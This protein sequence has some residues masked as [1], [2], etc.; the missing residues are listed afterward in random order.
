M[1]EERIIKEGM[2]T[3]MKKARVLL[4]NPPTA[5]Q[6]SEIILSLAYLASSLRKHGHEVKILDATAPYKS[7][8]AE[9]VK[10]DILDFSPH[11]IGVTLTITYIPQTYEY[12]MELRK[13]GIPIVAGGPHVNPLPGEAL[14]HGA[15]IVV[16]GEGENTIVE[17]ADHFAGNGQDL[18]SIAGLCMKDESGGIYKTP[19]RELIKNLDDIP[20]PSFEDFPI[21]NYTGSDDPESNPIFWAVFSSRGCP[22]NCTFCCGHNVFGRSYR[23]R[24]AQNV[25]DEMKHLAEKFG[26]KRIA[27]QD[28]EILVS[29]KRILELC[30][31]MK[32][33]NFKIKISIRARIDSVDKELLEVMRQ[34]GFHR[35]SFGI[36]SWDNETLK[37][38]TK[39]YNVDGIMKGMDTLARSPFTCANFNTMIGFPWETK[40]HMD[41]TL[42]VIRK[43]PRSIRYFNV[44]IAPIPFPN[45]KLYEE[46]HEKY[47]FTN[48]WLD[49]QKHW[50]SFYVAEGAKP[51][52]HR[53][54]KTM[55]TLYSPNIFWEYT[56]KQKR[57]MDGFVWKVFRLYTRRHLNF[58]DHMMT[59]LLCRLSYETWKVSPP[60]ERFL[61]RHCPEK[62]LSRISDALSFVKYDDSNLR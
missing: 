21:R 7:L 12:L 51:L 20:F 14:V 58:I 37:K 27:F 5:A 10:K 57:E 45:T 30:D 32:K 18:K 43:I 40:K 25:F 23:L 60:L 19:P 29:K 2:D 22:F 24:S 52:Y 26:A 11:F 55:T 49:P 6:S 9:E 44:A 28:D 56:P 15:D 46:Y 17:L 3:Y 50:D 13:L 62:F 59:Y 47:G 33:E 53:L 38:V 39:R 61:F 41:N 31:I 4:L 48:W 54:A 8:N 35:I 42:K 1:D 36:D 16:L 34:S